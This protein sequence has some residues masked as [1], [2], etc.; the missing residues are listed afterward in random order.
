MRL[1]L[2]LT[3]TRV[4]PRPAK[5][6][7][8]VRNLGWRVLCLAPHKGNPDPQSEILSLLFSK[9]S[10]VQ[11]LVS[12]PSVVVL[13]RLC[14]LRT[15]AGLIIP[16]IVHSN[17]TVKLPANFPII[18]I[19]IPSSKKPPDIAAYPPRTSSSCSQIK[20]KKVPPDKCIK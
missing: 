2:P 10:I 13:S 3:T 12:Y 9:Q 4:A 15:R 11:E 1:P 5:L 17:P 7:A 8:A 20:I 16:Y 18:F 19:A 14:L 6:P